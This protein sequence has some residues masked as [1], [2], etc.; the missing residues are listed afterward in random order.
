MSWKNAPKLDFKV[1]KYWQFLKTRREFKT[2]PEILVYKLNNLS[3]LPRQ[4]YKLTKN[5]LAFCFR[6]EIL[7]LLFGALNVRHFLEVGI[8]YSFCKFSRKQKYI[9][10]RNIYTTFIN[11]SWGIFGQKMREINFSSMCHI[12]VIPRGLR[13]HSLLMFAVFILQWIS[14][15]HIVTCVCRKPPLKTAFSFPGHLLPGGFSSMLF[16]QSFMDSIVFPF[17]CRHRGFRL[18]LLFQRLFRIFFMLCC[19]IYCNQFTQ[20]KIKF[21]SM[22]MKILSSFL[23]LSG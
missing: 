21:L 8:L 7:A 22:H 19:K 10:G 12:F 14:S 9:W 4:I 18:W 3:I 6:S 11:S 23:A 5:E 17:I 1:I 15:S 2:R 13:G 20:V 16:S